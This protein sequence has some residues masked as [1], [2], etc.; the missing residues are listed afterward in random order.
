MES[1]TRSFLA[2]EGTSPTTGS[3]PS[4]SYSPGSFDT[5]SSV[6]SASSDS[7]VGSLCTASSSLTGSPSSLSSNGK[8]IRRQTSRIRR[9]PAPRLTLEE[10]LALLDNEARQI[11]SEDIIE[12]KN[13]IGLLPALEVKPKAA[14]PTKAPTGLGHCLYSLVP[15]PPS[16]IMLP[17]SVNLAIPPPLPIIIATPATAKLPQQEDEPASPIPP[18]SP[19]VSEVA[20]QWYSS[21]NANT[22]TTKR[23]RLPSDVVKDFGSPSAKYGA[24]A[25]CRSSMAPSIESDYGSRAS[26][27]EGDSDYDSEELDDEKRASIATDTFGPNKHIRECKTGMCGHA[28]DQS[29]SEEEDGQDIGFVIEQDTPG[30]EYVSAIPVPASVSL[31]NFESEETDIVEESIRLSEYRWLS[32]RFIDH[33]EGRKQT[34]QSF[35]TSTTVRFPRS[36]SPT[37][38]TDTTSFVTAAEDPNTPSEPSES[39]IFETPRLS[40]VSRLPRPF[41]STSPSS[42]SLVSESGHSNAATVTASKVSNENESIFDTPAK[43]SSAFMRHRDSIYSIASDPATG[44]GVSPR[45]IIP[46]RKISLNANMPTRP[47]YTAATMRWDQI[48]VDDRQWKNGVRKPYLKDNPSFV[49]EFPP[50]PAGYQGYMPQLTPPKQRRN[51]RPSTA[52]ELSTCKRMEPIPEAPQSDKRRK[53]FSLV[54]RE[55]L[56]FHEASVKARQE[57]A[58]VKAEKKAAAKR[59]MNLYTYQRPEQADIKLAAECV[60]YT[61]TGAEV[62]FGDLYE[63]SRTIVCFIRHYW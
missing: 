50:P 21:P 32:K 8:V 35:S 11:P 63:G 36:R 15:D 41:I 5:P 1:P 43:R 16:A 62:R 29:E 52:P 9:K 14:P 28:S 22:A 34:N 26:A 54:M 10:E 37:Y 47:S 51:I 24:S 19:S 60:V 46:G 61:S 18:D 58:R 23:F 20:I 49:D 38:E 55:L 48:N 6:S 7:P 4:L 56:A 39:G 25:S 40:N 33:K 13:G 42:L 44:N 53:A 45:S 12:A 3:P 27:G 2:L 30:K 57:A 31:D 59:A 17:Q